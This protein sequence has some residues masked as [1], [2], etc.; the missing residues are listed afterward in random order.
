MSERSAALTLASLSD[1]TSGIYGKSNDI[2]R[3]AI[4]KALANGLQFGAHTTHEARLADHLTS[5]FPSM[6]FV[7]FANSGTEAN[8]LAITTALKH[9]KRKKVVV[10]SGGYHG[11]LLAH[12]HTGEPGGN[13]VPGAL[14]VPFVR[15]PMGA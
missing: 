4:T 12:F 2:L 5:R 3:G 15:L 7:R 14:R 11:S 9:T 13:D 6:D 1:F 10:F 8:L